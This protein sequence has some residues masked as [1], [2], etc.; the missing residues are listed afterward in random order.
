[1]P[2]DNEGFIKLYRQILD[3]PV[4]CKDSDHYAVW[5]YI[6]LTATH[7]EKK[8][9]FNGKPIILSPG[10]LIT[11]R[12]KIARKFNISESKVQRILKTFEIEQQI[13]QRTT[14][15]MR[16]ITVLN[17]S[18]YQTSEQRNKQRVN[19]DRTTTE[20]RLNTIQECKNDKN[21]KN[22][23]NIYIGLDKAV[24]DF[25]EYRKKIKKPMTDRAVELMVKKLD[26]M[27]QSEDEK[28]AILEQ[29]I[30]NG[31]QGIFPLKNKEDKPKEQKYSISI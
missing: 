23:R 14:P 26:S 19:N 30:L 28:I 6:L 27:A 21:V 7:K 5:G 13:E 31:W 18:E 9:Y 29:S 8:D 17:W 16:L 24:N 15:N 22:E 4:I 11:G 25:V 3:N 1:M 20:Q 12:I 10:Q 2:K